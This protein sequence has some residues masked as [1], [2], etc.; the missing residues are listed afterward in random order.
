M[1]AKIVCTAHQWS[2]LQKLQ[3]VWDKMKKDTLLRLITV[4]GKGE[5]IPE[6]IAHNLLYT[7]Q[8]G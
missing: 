5:N 8:G 1:R 7:S 6:K 2:Y 4:L 3:L